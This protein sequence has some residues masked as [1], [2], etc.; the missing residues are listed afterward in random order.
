MHMKRLGR[1]GLLAVTLWL[2]LIGVF[3]NALPAQEFAKVKADALK[4]WIESGEKSILIVDVQPKGAYNLGHIKGA[5]NF[6]WAADL[7]SPGDLPR[8]K[9]LIL[10]CDCPNEEDSQDAA[11]QLNEK[12]GY[13]NIKLLERGW[14]NWRK[15][16]YPTEK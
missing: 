8:D 4:Q 10:Y 11:N 3:P 15:M 13:S 1:K 12:W 5:I 9:T 6:P 7:K 14:S 2:A 16:G